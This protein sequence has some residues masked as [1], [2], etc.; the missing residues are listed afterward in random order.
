[1]NSIYIIMII[2][3]SIIIFEN[4]F[5]IILFINY[6][7]T[8]TKELKYQTT[9][10]SFIRNNSNVAKY[11]KQ[12]GKASDTF[13]PTGYPKNTISSK[14]VIIP[15]TPEQIQNEHYEELRKQ[16]YENY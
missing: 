4:A 6:S 8:I 7:Q 15:K 14:H 12:K 16:I 11:N 10:L 5:I 1:M 13:N 9:K 2:I 3:I